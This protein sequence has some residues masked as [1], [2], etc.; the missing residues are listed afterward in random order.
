[1]QPIVSHVAQIGISIEPLANVMQ[2]SADPSISADANNQMGKFESF[3][4]QTAEN[5]Y[6]Y[7][8]SFA[9]SLTHYATTVGQNNPNMQLIPTSAINNWYERFMRNLKQ[10]PNFLR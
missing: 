5:L 6:N 7:C 4:T 1:M 10:N 8:L 3:A 9:N 2:L